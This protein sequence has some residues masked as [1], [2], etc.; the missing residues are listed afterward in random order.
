[1]KSTI[2]VHDLPEKDVIVLEELVNLLRKKTEKE[3][4]P[5]DRAEQKGKKIE[6]EQGSLGVKGTL[7][8]EEIYDYL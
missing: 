1:M 5:I 6:F 3:I 4:T 7:S 2:D 8:R